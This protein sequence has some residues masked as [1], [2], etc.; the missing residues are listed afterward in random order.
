MLTVGAAG[1]YQQ[2]V[3]SDNNGA[4]INRVGGVGPEVVGLCPKCG[5]FVS[6]RYAYEY[7]AENRLQGHTIALTVTRKF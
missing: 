1:Y 2:Q 4:P 3:T 7:L 6:L 5:I